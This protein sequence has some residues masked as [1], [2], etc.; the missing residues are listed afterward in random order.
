MSKGNDNSE[1]SKT[2]N[3]AIHDV[4]NYRKENGKLSSAFFSDSHG[5]SVDFD[6]GRGIGEIYSNFCQRF[7]NTYTVTGIGILQISDVKTI[8]NITIKADPLQDN[9]N[10]A[11]I[12]R[13]DG[14]KQLTKGQK[15]Q[16]A[17]FCTEYS[18]QKPLFAKKRKD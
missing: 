7:A 17:N 16:L 9:K 4:P 2:L 6:N 11:M 10:H 1:F 15:R 5:V 14:T 3:R 12:I 8:N 18:P 13:S